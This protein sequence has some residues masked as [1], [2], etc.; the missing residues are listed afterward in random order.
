MSYEGPELPVAPARSS[1]EIKPR[2]RALFYSI[3]CA[4]G[5]AFT[6]IT[7]L[8]FLNLFSKG[9]QN[10]HPD[11]TADLKILEQAHVPAY[12]NWTYDED[13]TKQIRY[14]SNVA[15]NLKG[16]KI[17]KQVIAMQVPAEEKATW[18]WFETEL[19]K[20]GYKKTDKT[21]TIPFAGKKVEQVIFARGIQRLA[22]Q[23]LPDDE[24][25]GKSIIVFSW[26]LFA[27]PGNP[28]V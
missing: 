21:V 24:F 23:V 5:A 20:K 16:V 26:M 27:E 7:L 18:T 10:I 3:G 22:V 8:L 9:S 13:T 1:K 19:L 15:A 2:S 17:D 4:G 11:K 14:A 6:L 12:P 28:N 25:P